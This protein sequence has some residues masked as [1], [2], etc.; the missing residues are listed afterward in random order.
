MEDNSFARTLSDANQISVDFLI[1]DVRI[2]LTFLD[3]AETTKIARD[4]LR[5][6]GEA[7]QAYDS[8][9]SFLPCATPTDEQKEVL[10]RGLK[11]LKERL[12]VLGVSFP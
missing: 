11:V 3:L 10:S 2:A 12:R 7:K 1:N 6:I 4:R 8:I 9:L 5:R